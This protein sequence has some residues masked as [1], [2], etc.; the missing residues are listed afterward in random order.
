MKRVLITAFEPYDRWRENSSWLA[1]IEFTSRLPSEP[2]ITTRRYPVDFA[3]VR[4][5]LEE[6]LAAGYDLALHLGQS[7]GSGSIHLERMALNVRG[8]TGLPTESLPPLVAE[9]PLALESNAPLR[10]WAQAIRSLGI[11]ARVSYHAGVYLCNATLYLSRYLCDQMRLDTRAAFVHLP[12][13]PVQALEQPGDLA[14]LA[15]AQAAAALRAI[16]AS[17]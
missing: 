6:D 9:G 14:S 15:P 11:P 2:K 16:V 13:A 10:D 8:E 5:R 17:L 12:L 1:L 4:T 7:P 3:A